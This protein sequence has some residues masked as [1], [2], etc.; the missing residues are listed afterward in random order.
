VNYGLLLTQAAATKL[1]NT[2]L[3]LNKCPEI[4]QFPQKNLNSVAELIQ[5]A[6]QIL[7]LGSKFLFFFFLCLL[8]K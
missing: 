4:G 3:F 8:L 1:L 6:N 7:L 5:A 2:H